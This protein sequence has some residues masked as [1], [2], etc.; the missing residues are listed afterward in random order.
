MFQC[1]KEQD[2]GFSVRI[3]LIK[4]LLWRNKGLS[5]HFSKKSA[6]MYRQ[7]VSGLT[8]PITIQSIYTYLQGLG[9]VGSSLE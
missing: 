3:I 6:S 9:N 2:K 8:L 1:L 7:P 4:R 5:V